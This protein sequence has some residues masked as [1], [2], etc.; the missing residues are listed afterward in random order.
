MSMGSSSAGM[1]YSLI[2]RQGRVLP[3]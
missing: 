2:G 1:S 3:S